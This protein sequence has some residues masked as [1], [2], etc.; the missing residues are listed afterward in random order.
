MNKP[1]DI[2]GLGY[3]G[4]DYLCLT[5]HIPVDDKVEALMTLTQGGGPSATATFAAA[6]LGARTAFIGATGNDERGRSIVAGL[7]DD[8]VNTDA[9]AIRSGAD[10]PAAFCWTEKTTGHRSI[11][12]TR[13]GVKPLTPEEIDPRMIKSTKL[14]H[15]D[16]HQTAAAAH[17]ANIARMNGVTVSIDAGT[18]VPD[19]EKILALSDI[20]IASEKFAEKFT[21]A[22]KPEIAVKKLF[23]GNCRFAAVT[24]GAKGSIGFD[25]KMIY[26][27]SSFKVKV[28]DTTGA[29][30]VFHGA[31]AYRHLN[32]GDWPACLRFA[33]AVAALKCTKFGGR[34]G[35]PT[36][37]ETER[38][39]QENK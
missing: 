18:I 22:T 12:W 20:V 3:C 27:Q 15:L 11:V 39:L 37:A 34:T 30:D 9:I 21:G 31:F 4:L 17:A 10:S 26:E 5:P 32:G 13:G 36:L 33:A 29:G 24:M 16:G 38:F 8:G 1:Y 2:I 35:I 14:L 25:G 7:R 6:R 28:L 19:I 23:A